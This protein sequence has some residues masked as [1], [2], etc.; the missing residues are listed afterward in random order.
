MIWIGTVLAPSSIAIAMRIGVDVSRLQ[1]E[2]AGAQDLPRGTTL[3]LTVASNLWMAVLLSAGVGIWA[4][5]DGR[6]CTLVWSIVSMLAI[7]G[8]VA[9]I[10]QGLALPL[11]VPPTTPIR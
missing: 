9:L 7:I 2:M 10:A 1:Y 11:D 5:R 4:V 3:A 6:R 8:A